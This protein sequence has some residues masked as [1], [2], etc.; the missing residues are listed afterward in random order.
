[1]NNITISVQSKSTLTFS[2]KS[3]T[4]DFNIVSQIFTHFLFNIAIQFIFTIYIQDILQ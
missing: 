3:S 1:M 4:F 2:K